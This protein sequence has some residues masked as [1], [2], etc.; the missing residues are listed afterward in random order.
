MKFANIPQMSLANYSVHHLLHMLPRTIRRY[1][2]ETLCPLNINPDFQRAHVW[3]PE[4]KIRYM[5]FILQ[6]GTSAKDFYFNCC[7]WQKSYDG[8]FELVDGKQRLDACLGFMSGTVPVFGGLY[9][10][11]FTD[12]PFDVHLSFHINNLKTRTEVLRWYLDINSG[13]VVHTNDE[14]DKV[15][16]LL[17]KERKNNGE[18]EN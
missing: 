2:E 17:E 5:E 18:K 7:G 9:I 1:Q 10:T 14:L 8:P 3:T 6:G 11:D 13:G 16:E 12:K 4:Q 15:R